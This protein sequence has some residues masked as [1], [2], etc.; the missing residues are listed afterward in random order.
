M[1]DDQWGSKDLRHQAPAGKLEDCARI[2]AFRN[3]MV[4]PLSLVAPTGS[5]SP[6][7]SLMVERIEHQPEEESHVLIH[8]VITLFLDPGD[9]VYQHGAAAQSRNHKNTGDVCIR[10][11]GDSER[12]I[13]RTPAPILLVQVSAYVLKATARSLLGYE[14]ATLRAATRV[15][16]GSVTGILWAL[17]AEQSRGYPS[18]RLF[19]DSLEL[20]LATRLVTGHSTLSAVPPVRKGGMAP[21]RLRRVLEFIRE[22]LHAQINLSDLAAIADLSLSH[23]SSQFRR[24]TG[25]SPYRY[26]R[27]LRIDRSRELLKS[28]DIPILRIANAVGFEN[29]QHFS[30]VFRKVVGVS[31]TTYR[32]HS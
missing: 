21:R 29:Q 8:D 11:R 31:P 3:G 9:L 4:E 12:I 2:V 5:P 18:G 14:L 25:E 1:I 30:T 7:P 10:T 24:S 26:V 22:N 32:L 23:F 6:S 28:Q 20:A 16:D 19:V 17:E 13:W 27:R 15:A